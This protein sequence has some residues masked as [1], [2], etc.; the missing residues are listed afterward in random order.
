M[1]YFRI[2]GIRSAAH[3]Q[4]LLY[5]SCEGKSRRSREGVGHFK[6][7]DQRWGRARCDRGSEKGMFSIQ[8]LEGMLPKGR[9]GDPRYQ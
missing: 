1:K 4:L 3:F 5:S 9:D 2:R 8:L 7:F 6:I